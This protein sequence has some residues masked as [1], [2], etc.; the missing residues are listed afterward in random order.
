MDVSILCGGEGTRL[1]PLTYIVPKPLLPFGSKP[2]L[3]V[4]LLRMKK[5]GFRKFY[6]MVDYKADMIRNYFGNGESL[7]IDIKY[8]KETTS[9]GTA[10]PLSALRERITSP[11]VV[12]NGDLLTDL[13]FNKMMD[14]HRSENA[15]LTIALKKYQRK[16]AY[17]IVEID[18]DSHIIQ[19][20]E[21][22]ELTFLINSG[23]YIL[24]PNVFSLIPNE[25]KYLMTDL[26]DKMIKNGLNVVG[27]EFTEAWHDIGRLDDYMK[28]I[29]KEDDH[30]DDGSDRFLGAP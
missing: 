3:E 30:P 22:P 28:T 21:K 7:G 25:G 2:I 16:F 24:S 12:M 5:Q 13:N 6:L 26:I 11:L 4:I 18:S 14:F 27:Y 1:R 29:L 19:I 17:G 8:I 10:G 15:N 9:R 23:I 20:K